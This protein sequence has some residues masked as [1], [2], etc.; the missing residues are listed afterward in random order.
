MTWQNLIEQLLAE[1]RRVCETGKLATVLIMIL[2][3]M[4]LMQWTDGRIYRL[5]LVT[6]GI[7]VLISLVIYVL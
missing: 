4:V 1:L 3:T 5:I 7:C 6:S 2:I